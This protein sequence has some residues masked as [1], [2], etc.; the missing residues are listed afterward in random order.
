MEYS[1][2]KIFYLKRKVIFP[3]SS[4]VVMVK[5]SQSAKEIEKG[6]MIIT[7]P[8]RSPLDIIF[9]RMKV[10]TI[11]EVVTVE[12]AGDSV[13]LGLKGL[14]R[15]KLK[16]I[17]SYQYAYYNEIASEQAGTVDHIG[18]ELRK[19]SQELIFLINVE[20]SDMLINLMNY[21]SSVDQLTDFVSN[22][23]IIDFRKRYKIYRE[24]DL[25]R[26]GA[27][28]LAMLHDLIEKIVE[29]RER[30]NDGKNPHK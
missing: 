11:S 28:V 24:L 8:I 25:H 18:E 21:I 10:A 5:A 19:K 13:K 29:R 26:R 20:E 30:E 2:L 27:M 9:Q 3:Y 14:R 12:E 16:K 23:F 7:Y 15:V 1:K 4:L 17:V 22:Y 6:E